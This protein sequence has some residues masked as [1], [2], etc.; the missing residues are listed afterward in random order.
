M[1]IRFL[2]LFLVV[3]LVLSACRAF[4][5]KPV[6][7]QRVSDAPAHTTAQSFTLTARSVRE[8]RGV[9]S[10]TTRHE[11][12]VGTGEVG[13]HEM[14]VVPLVDPGSPLGGEVFAWVTP[15]SPIQ[16]GQSPEAWFAQL[17]SELDDHTVTVKVAARAAWAKA[18]NAGWG[19]AIADAEARY[20]LTSDPNAPVL[21]FPPPD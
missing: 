6:V 15:S 3:V 8:V 20:H 4:R 7:L 14:W 1:M 17:A 10:W 12:S 11:R 19:R 16:G 9:G 18:N 2:G 13:T 21:F 5:P